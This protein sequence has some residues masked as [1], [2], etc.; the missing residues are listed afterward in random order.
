[1]K[2]VLRT[3]LVAGLVISLGGCSIFKGGKGPKTPVLGQR[4]AILTSE[5]GVEVDPSLADVAVLLPE[6]ET[7]ADWPQPGGNAA[8]S[9]NHVAVPRSLGSVWHV[10]I[11]GTSKQ[12]R[13]GAA[14][15]VEGGHVYVMDTKAQVH[16][17]DAANGRALWTVD[18]GANKEKRSLFGGGVSAEAGVLYVT[19]GIGD[20]AALKADNG[21]VIWKKRPG[22]PLRGA[23]SI[24][25][26]NIYV[27]SQDNQL[28][29]MKQT[30]GNLEWTGSASLELA[31]V[32]GVGAPAVGQGTVVAGFSS[33]ELNAWRYEN[34]RS[35][36]GDALSRT[37]ISTSVASLADIDAS[38]VIDRG[39]VFAIGE[40]GRM[41]SMD[42]VTGQRLWESN[43]AGIATPWVS[44]EWVFVVTDEAKLLC[45]A[46][47]TGKVRWQL[48]L[49]RYRVEKKKKDPISWVGPILA[50]GRLIIGASDGR[51]ANVDP[52]NGQ[53][54]SVVKAGGPLY[55][56]PIV[57]NNTLFTLDN[58]GHLTAWR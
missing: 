24:G 49:P 1:M 54:Q 50:G 32:F 15:V 6:A 3:A 37:S 31:G 25:N 45:L 4:V 41:V 26:G 46:R 5:S 2:A 14:P 48:Q 42:L 52:A 21:S 12:V 53:L 20:V 44:G 40:G 39:R 11:P 55:F 13:L 56:A 18:F 43:L 23:P 10:S 57:A 34:G 47:A 28:Y 30:D 7:N 9:M 58:N 27:M 19:N 22:G 36:W 51:M 29:A 35:L 8:K 38:P 33:G 16:A 17:F